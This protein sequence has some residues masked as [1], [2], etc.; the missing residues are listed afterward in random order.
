MVG[1]N[2][3]RILLFFFSLSSFLSF[4]PFLFFLL[5]FEL[6]LYSSFYRSSTFGI[7]ERVSGSNVRY[8][9]NWVKLL[10]SFHWLKD[11]ESFWII[12]S[13]RILF[14]LFFFQKVFAFCKIVL[15][16]NNRQFNHSSM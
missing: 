7:V 5:F 8:Y 3:D 11:C 16:N 9:Q 1:G 10:F 12:N 2:I 6:Q 13:R 15:N 4:F 14:Y